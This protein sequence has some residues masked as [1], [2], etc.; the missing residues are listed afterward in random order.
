MITAEIIVD[1]RTKG[2]KGYPLKVRVYCSNIQKHRYIAL[3]MYQKGKKLMLTPQVSER[4]QEL[5]EQVEYCNSLGLDLE[6]AI[7]AIKKGGK[8]Q[9]K[10]L[11]QTID[12]S[13]KER[14]D[15]GMST[16]ALK[17]I[18][19][20]FENY[21]GQD[22]PMTVVDY[23]WV[24][25][26]ITYKKK[27]GTGEGGI[28]YYIRTASTLFNEFQRDKE[29]PFKGHRIKRKRTTVLKL[30]TWEH[31]RLLDSFEPQGRN[32]ANN[33]NTLKKVHLFKFQ[34]HIGGHYISDLHQIEVKNERIVFQRFKNRSKEGGGELIDNQLTDYAKWFI[35][36]YGLDWFPETELQRRYFRNNYNKT[37]QRV[38][39]QLGIEPKL[40]SSTPRYLFRTAGGEC[41]A[42]EFAVNQLMG[43]KP[44]REKEISY[45]Y[46][47]RLPNRLIDEEH[48]RILEHIFHS[49]KT[50]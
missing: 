17:A 41:R 6:N 18:K 50:L 42:F 31:I 19:R 35:G 12:I 39:N 37:L 16:S 24:R 46:Q 25:D 10:G 44:P 3:K 26:F 14:K 43:H 40:E 5:I 23:M 4:S 1:T 38:S 32:S 47:R 8:K 11:L 22:I 21:I 49:P 45:G 36:E 34:I 2:A 33:R 28:S 13:I 48:N 15:R 30:P 7:T 27:M 9:A 20:E 29:N